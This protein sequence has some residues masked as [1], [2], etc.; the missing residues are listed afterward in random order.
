[1]KISVVRMLRTKSDIFLTNSKITHL[2]CWELS[3]CECISSSCRLYL[4]VLCVFRCYIFRID[5]SPCW[6]ILRLGPWDFPEGHVMI[7]NLHWTAKPW[8]PTVESV[9]GDTQALWHCDLLSG[10]IPLVSMWTLSWGNV[11]VWG[12]TYLLLA[13]PGEYGFQSGWCFPGPWPKRKI[14]FQAYIYIL[15][16]FVLTVLEEIDESILVPGLCWK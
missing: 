11:T 12:N 15:Q 2:P 6:M 5:I 16:G 3:V 9:Y 1:M 4:G 8:V 13:P 10:K 7:E 14:I